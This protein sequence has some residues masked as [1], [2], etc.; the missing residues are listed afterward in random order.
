MTEKCGFERNLVTTDDLS[1]HHLLDERQMKM[2]D[3]FY[4]RTVLEL[5]R[6]TTENSLN[7]VRIASLEVKLA[8]AETART[9]T[10]SQNIFIRNICEK[11]E[12]QHNATCNAKTKECRQN[13]AN[14]FKEIEELLNEKQKLVA[15]LNEKDQKIANLQKKLETLNG[16]CNY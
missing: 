8:A 7:L 16:N 13:V 14:K 10:D 4:N 5:Q 2:F 1:G 9:R 6:K 12:A 3:T 15:S 11:L